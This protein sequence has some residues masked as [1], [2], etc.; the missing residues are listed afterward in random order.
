MDSGPNDAEMDLIMQGYGFDMVRV[1][2]GVWYSARATVRLQVG[3]TCEQDDC[4]FDKACSCRKCRAV[5]GTR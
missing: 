3:Y 4:G 2:T 5:L 1:P